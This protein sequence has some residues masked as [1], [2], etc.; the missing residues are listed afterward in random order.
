M[1]NPELRR[2]APAPCWSDC[3]FSRQARP[4]PGTHLIGVLA[5]EGIGPEVITGALRV[6][7]AVESVTD[8]R[9]RIEFGTAIGR[10]SEQRGG[11]ALP[12]EVVDFCRRIFD[13]GGA[14]LNGPGGGRYV[15]DLRRSFDL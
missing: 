9:F 2:A 5:G 13:Q 4:S 7:S 15:Y 10:E 6:L 14:V 11:K 1:H 8:E 3:L 12:D